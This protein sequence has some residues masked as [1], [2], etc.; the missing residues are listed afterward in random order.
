MKAECLGTERKKKKSL[1]VAWEFP[2]LP[3]LPLVQG[4]FCISR[5]MLGEVCVLASLEKGTLA[6]RAC[7]HS[8][9]PFCLCLQM[10]PGVGDL[11]ASMEGT[12]SFCLLSQLC[13]LGKSVLF[14][15]FELLSLA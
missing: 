5:A 12:S 2:N 4:A 13:Y 15:F 3:S 11:P 7:L 9:G 1:K 10:R 6:S 14:L 8:F